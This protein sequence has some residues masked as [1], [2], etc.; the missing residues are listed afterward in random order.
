MRHYEIVLMIH[1]DQTSEQLIKI[2]NIYKQF[3]L[4]NNGLIHRFEDW[5]RRQLAYSVKKLRKAYY[6]LMNI[7]LS[8]HNIDQFKKILR[9]DNFVIRNL[10]LNVKNKINSISPMLKIKDEKKVVKL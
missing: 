9:F 1:P 2:I 3:I 7:E 10:I 4:K 6:I 5:G 8:P